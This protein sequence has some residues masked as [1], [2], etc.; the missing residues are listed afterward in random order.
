M[1]LLGGEQGHLTE[2]YLNVI[3]HCRILIQLAHVYT[4]LFIWS[5]KAQITNT[6][7]FSIANVT[8]LKMETEIYVILYYMHIRIQRYKSLA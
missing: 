4:I 3:S 5:S 6:Q 8:S 7:A 1:E 2:L